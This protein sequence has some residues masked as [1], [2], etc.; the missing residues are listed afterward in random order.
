MFYD[1]EFGKDLL[2]M[3]PKAQ[4]MKKNWIQYEK[5]L[6]IKGYYYQSAKATHGMK[7]MMCKS[8]I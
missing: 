5:H 8:H 6:H 4:T 1:I 7:V 3:T 2:D